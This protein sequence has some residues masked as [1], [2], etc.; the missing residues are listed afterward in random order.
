MTLK[1]R[2]SHLPSLMAA[3]WALVRHHGLKEKA[4]DKASASSIRDAFWL[5][6]R[7]AA[8]AEIVRTMNTEHDQGERSLRA[9]R[10]ALEHNMRAHLKHTAAALDAATLASMLS[11][12]D[13]KAMLAEVMAVARVRYPHTKPPHLMSILRLFRDFQNKPKA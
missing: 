13:F 3:A 6:S 8:V 4:F 12:L 7:G 2:P 5:I 10:A 9:R 1:P 11:R